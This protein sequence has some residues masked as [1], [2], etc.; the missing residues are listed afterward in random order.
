M[1]VPHTT[2]LVWTGKSGAQG[3][4]WGLLPEHCGF[5]VYSRWNWIT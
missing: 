3:L 2:H 1:D 4:F 5:C